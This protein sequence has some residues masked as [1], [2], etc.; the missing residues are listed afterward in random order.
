MGIPFLVN[1]AETYPPLS[2]AD[3]SGKLTGMLFEMLNVA[4]KNVNV[5]LIYKYPKDHNV[6][7]WS[8]K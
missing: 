8:E 3:E 6:D 1:Y 7:I 4:A 5:T 2:Y